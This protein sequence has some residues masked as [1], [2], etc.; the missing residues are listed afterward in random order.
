[1]HLKGFGLAIFKYDSVFFEIIMADEDTPDILKGQPCPMCR[2]NTLTLT[3]AKRDIP[4]F[5]VCY[6]FSMD[7]SSCD[8]HMADIESEE[9]KDPV[10]YSIDVET[11]DDLK[12]RVV[13]SSKAT[14]KI[15][16][17]IE[18]S[19][20]PVANGYVTNVEGVLSRAKK[21]IE[22]QKAD[23]DDSSKRKKLKNMLKKIQDVLWGRGSLKIII[24]DPSGNSAIV[25]E[26][27]VKSKL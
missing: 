19:P 24:S 12:I 22:S 3:E 7:C 1:M 4:F 17:I 23:E 21:I 13:K 9:E 15:P 16:R 26:K 2:K 10:K 18:M 27:A 6:I 8:Y 14:L 11:E 20:G 5:G 25:S